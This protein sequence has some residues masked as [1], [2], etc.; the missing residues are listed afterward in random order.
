MRRQVTNG[1]K[2]RI[3]IYNGTF[4][5]YVLNDVDGNFYGNIRPVSS[6]SL[7]LNYS[8]TFEKQYNLSAPNATISFWL[9]ITGEVSRVTSTPLIRAQIG[10]SGQN[11]FNEQG[12][13]I[14]THIP[15][16]NT[17]TLLP[18]NPAVITLGAPENGFTMIVPSSPV[19]EPL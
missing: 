12:F 10:F 15:V 14:Q 11:L 3:F 7:N 9:K 6:Y 4:L 8:D 16:N 18:A 17:I 19:I 2:N 1:A 13:T 5:D